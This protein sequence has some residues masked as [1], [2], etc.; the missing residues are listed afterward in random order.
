MICRKIDK[1]ILPILAW[2][3]FLQILD[4]SVVGYA[5]N[6]GMKTDAVSHLSPHGSKKILISP[7]NDSPLLV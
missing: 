5:A 3:Y 6:F 1:V 7:P 2:V 4:K